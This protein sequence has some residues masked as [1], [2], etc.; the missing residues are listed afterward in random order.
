MIALT[1]G[2]RKQNKKP[3]KLK[4]DQDL[5]GGGRREWLKVVEKV[6]TSVIR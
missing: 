2:I 6:Q 5:V 4:K 3:H 1:R